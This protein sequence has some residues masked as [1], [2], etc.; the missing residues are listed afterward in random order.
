MI[1]YYAFI[2]VVWCIHLDEVGLAHELP[3][4]KGVGQTRQAHISTD[5]INQ[6]FN[7]TA[8]IEHCFTTLVGTFKQLIGS[9]VPW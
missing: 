3:L 4:L 6:L 7:T 2:F 9:V 5:E 8:N 1:M